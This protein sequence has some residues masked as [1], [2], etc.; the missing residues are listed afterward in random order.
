ME[1]A[2]LRF[3]IIMLEAQKAGIEAEL[4]KLR[5]TPCQVCKGQRR[6]VKTEEDPRDHKILT[7]FLDCEA[8]NGSGY[9]AGE[10]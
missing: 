2:D 6:I 9:A 7:I 1:T 4:I 5:E 10:H 8:C 3:R